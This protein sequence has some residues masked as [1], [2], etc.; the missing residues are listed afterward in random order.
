MLVY[1]PTTSMEVIVSSCF[2]LIP[3]ILLKK[4]NN[5]EHYVSY[6]ELRVEKT[7]INLAIYIHIYI[8]RLIYFVFKFSALTAI[9]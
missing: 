9:P 4:S 1:K 8:L 2:R 5:F 6:Y 3:L 7:P